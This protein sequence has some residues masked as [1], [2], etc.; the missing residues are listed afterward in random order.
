MSSCD[1][2]SLVM[3]IDQYLERS[4]NLFAEN[5]TASPFKAKQAKR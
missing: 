3:F 4:A 5:I 1:Q 2:M